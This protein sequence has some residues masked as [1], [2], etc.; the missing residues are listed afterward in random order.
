MPSFI[1]CIRATILLCSLFSSSTKAYKIHSSCQPEKTFVKDA[2]DEAFTM[3]D[4]ALDELRSSPRDP[5]VNRLLGLLFAK[6]D[7][8]PAT[9]DVT[10]LV[11]T[12][13]GIRRAATENEARPDPIN[14]DAQYNVWVDGDSRMIANTARNIC[15]P[16]DYDTMAIT[17][18]PARSTL[19]YRPSQMTICP[20]FFQWAHKQEYKEYSKVKEGINK[21]RARRTWE[22]FSRAMFGRNKGFDSMRMLE[23]TILHEL[24]HTLAGGVLLDV[25]VTGAR[26]ERD[27]YGWKTCLALAKNGGTNPDNGSPVTAFDNAH[28]VANFGLA[29]RLLRDQPPLYV[30]EDGG[31]TDQM[32]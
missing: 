17:W 31:V 19:N 8:D 30:L 4:L 2:A 11:S 15:S 12:L 16:T 23:Q 22:A 28:S 21:A 32:P 24:T 20:W 14:R 25:Q 13:E 9:M 7:Q 26:K 27:G 3:A 1:L 10:R 29:V 5:Q 6:K 18:N